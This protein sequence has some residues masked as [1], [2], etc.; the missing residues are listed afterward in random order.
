MGIEIKYPLGWASSGDS[1]FRD[2]GSGEV[3][4]YT[5]LAPER[6]LYTR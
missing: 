1:L 6:Y 3:P 5:Y 4:I 2:T